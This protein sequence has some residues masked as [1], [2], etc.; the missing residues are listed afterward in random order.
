MYQ[1]NSL[2]LEHIM[3]FRRNR[4]Q[5]CSSRVAHF[6]LERE[7]VHTGE[8]SRGRERKSQAG[9]MFSTEPDAGLDPLTLGSWPEPK[10]RVTQLTEPPPELLLLVKLRRLLGKQV[11]YRYVITEPH[12][13]KCFAISV[14]SILLSSQWP[15]DS[16]EQVGIFFG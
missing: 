2:G 13:S 14:P 10:S 1:V 3:P 9:S 11:E 12:C 6:F 8:R 4:N 16:L 15:C 7:S 5:K